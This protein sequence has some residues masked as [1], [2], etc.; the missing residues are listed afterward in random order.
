MIDEFRIVFQHGGAPQHFSNNV[1]KVLNSRF[2]T[3]RLEGTGPLGAPP[4]PPPRN[5]DL[6]PLNF[7]QWGHVKNI[8]LKENIADIANLKESITRT[9]ECYEY[10]QKLSIDVICAVLSMAHIFKLCNTV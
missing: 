2:P 10:G 8:E 4:P 3:N 5:P 1:R 7:F 9:I 6:T